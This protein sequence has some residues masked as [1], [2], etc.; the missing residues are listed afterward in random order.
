MEKRKHSKSDKPSTGV[1]IF[2]WVC[3]LF[4][5]IVMVWLI[6]DC[7]Q[8]I[9]R[10]KQID[11]ACEACC[12]TIYAEDNLRECELNCSFFHKDFLHTQKA[13]AV[14]NTCTQ[15]LDFYIHNP[16]MRFDSKEF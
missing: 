4:A 16:N 10:D 11:K 3:A 15:W 14:T 6:S 8:Q 12:G 2:V 5:A 13:H 1:Q 9:E 7:G